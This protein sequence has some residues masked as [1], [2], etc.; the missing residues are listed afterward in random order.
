MTQAEI[1]V[2]DPLV[3][4]FHWSL[5]ITFF[6]CFVT[7]DEWLRLHVVS[8]YLIGALVAFRLLW[9]VIGTKHARFTD[10]VKSPAEVRRY[11][12]DILRFRPRRYIGHNPAGGAMVIA[13]LA[14]LSVVV[15]TGLVVYG[16][17]EG[18]GPLA[19]WASALSH[20][21][22]EFLEEIHEFFANLSLFLVMLHLGGVLLASLQHGE[23]LV[24]AMVTGRKRG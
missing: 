1:K 16:V 11:L 15:L 18:A 14:S 5:A 9:G 22:G 8:G 13:L 12:G 7:E 4:I 23:N 21:A 24:A 6:V 2:W 17:E 19:S 3:R 10:F 20:G